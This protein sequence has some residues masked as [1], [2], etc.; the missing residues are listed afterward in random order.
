MH[1]RQW[2]N[3]IPN[4]KEDAFVKS[5]LFRMFDIFFKFQ[6]SQIK[7]NLVIYMDVHYFACSPNVFAHSEQTLT[8]L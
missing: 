2:A 3:K 8:P 4:T 7:P 5:V 6:A 1:L